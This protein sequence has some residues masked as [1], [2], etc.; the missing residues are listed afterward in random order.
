MSI[1]KAEKVPGGYRFT[2]RKS[3]GSLTPVWTRLGLHGM[4]TSDPANPKVVHGFLPRSGGGFTIKETWD[5]MGMRATRSDDTLLEGAFIPDQNIARVVP[6]GF[7]GADISCSASSR[8]RSS[9]SATSTM[10]S[11]SGPSTWPSNRSKQR[12]RW[13]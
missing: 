12:D 8:G 3:F 11:R 1:T 2:G 4:D 9:T 7:G 10:G 13:G 6:A 5:M